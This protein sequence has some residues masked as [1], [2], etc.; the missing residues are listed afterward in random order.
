M[1]NAEAVDSKVMAGL[2]AMLVIALLGRCAS[3]SIYQMLYAPRQ[4][5]DVQQGHGYCALTI[6]P[7]VL[8]IGLQERLEA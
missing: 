8:C 4:H 2:S 5:H 7:S 1:L 6:E 3:P